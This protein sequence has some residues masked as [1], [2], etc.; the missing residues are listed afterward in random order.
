MVDEQKKEEDNVENA[1][2]EYFIKFCLPDV[3]TR[4]SHSNGVSWP[5]QVK[6]E[7]SQEKCKQ[8]NKQI[9]P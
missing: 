9:T 6:R 1:M 7:R 4:V 2:R 8:T 3:Y 5:S